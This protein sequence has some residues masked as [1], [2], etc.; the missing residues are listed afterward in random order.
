LAL[1]GVGAVV[2]AWLLVPKVVILVLLL[3]R[4]STDGVME[5]FT[6][7]AGSPLSMN[8]AGAMN[9][10]AVGLGF[11]SLLRR[12]VRRQTVLVA[13]P[14]QTYALFLAAC[15]LSLPGAVDLV[16][17]IKEWARLASGLAIYLMVS[18][19]VRDEKE[20]RQFTL[21]ILASSLI[22]VAL[23][24]VQWLTGSGYFFPG[25]VGTEFA[26]RPLGTFGHP[27]ALGSYLVILVALL[28]TL[29]FAWSG[30]S[31]AVLLAWAGAAAGCLVL[32]MARAQWLG[33]LV[34]VLVVGVVKRRRL[35][36]GVL[37]LAAVLVLAVPLLQER[38]GAS[39]SVTWRIELWRAASTLAWP[40]TLLGRGLGSFPK[41]IN[42]ILVTVETHP[43]N[44]YLKVAVEVGLFGMVTYGAWLLAALRHAWRAY[45]R[46]DD[47]G[48]S[49]RALG[50][51]AVIVAG[52]VMGVVVHYLGI[53]A[54]Q[55]YLWAL[56]AL[57][58]AGGRWL[59]AA[60]GLHL[61]AQKSSPSLPES[62]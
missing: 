29:Y 19:V 59:P 22:P 8:L 45:R 38:L 23:G 13:G 5:L 60:G 16:G 62:P 40:P 37:L 35:A 4:S 25:F 55:W 12:L 27:S 15:L 31:R 41:V 33:L 54:V 17:G 7:F 39:E 46:A 2:L 20:V 3:L 52:L 61:S 56:V 1:V 47:P 58:P 44:D 26:F 34:A 49:W 10:L 50:L 36:F 21:V 32:T 11:L 9:S 24:W 42:Q 51:L 53:T 57:V 28:I 43:H 14:G 30:A 6:L 18:E 48:I